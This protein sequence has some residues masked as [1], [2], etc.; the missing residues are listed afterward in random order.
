MMGVFSSGT[1]IENKVQTTSLMA[2]VGSV[3]AAVLN[4]VGAHSELLGSLPALAQF[5]IIAAI[6]PAVTFLRVP[7]VFS[8][9]RAE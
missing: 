2:L 7:A 8:T 4:A 3:G 6:P 5:I 9:S 1:I